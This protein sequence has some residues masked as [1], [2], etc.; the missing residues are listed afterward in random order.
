[1]VV[2]AYLELISRFDIA[3]KVP[4]DGEVSFA[5]LADMLG[6][7]CAAVTSI[8]RLGIAHRMFREPR[9]GF[10]AHS[11]VS[12]QLAVNTGI[13]SWIRNGVDD[14]WPA[15][16]KIVDALIKWPR[17]EEPNQTVCPFFFFFFYPRH[18]QRELIYYQG[19][20]ISPRD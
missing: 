1:M 14:M 8:L 18:G 2:V 16:Q 15:C 4:I 3:S 12:R 11:A 6:F 7:N 5:S 13:A 20:F 9:R 17:A 10:I 19:L